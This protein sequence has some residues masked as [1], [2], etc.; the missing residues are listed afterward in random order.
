MENKKKDELQNRREFFKKAAKSAL[1][2]FGIA[3]IVSN[4]IVAKTLVEVENGCGM[5]CKFSC[6]GNCAGGCRTSCSGGCKT[7]CKGTCRH[8]NE[9]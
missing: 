7:L 3:L 9:F 2:I 4:P 1:P 8:S 5:G 6:V